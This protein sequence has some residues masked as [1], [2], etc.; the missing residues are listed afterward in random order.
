MS[1]NF[2]RKV[3]DTIFY[4][5]SKLCCRTNIISYYYHNTLFMDS[6]V[7]AEKIPT[8]IVTSLVC[9]KIRHCVNGRD[10]PGS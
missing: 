1:P 2:F 4:T 9:Q 7:G 10:R 6:I 5:Y 8:R 3:D